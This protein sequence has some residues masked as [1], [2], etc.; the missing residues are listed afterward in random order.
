ML[1]YINSH[2]SG[3]WIALGFAMLAA[4]VLLFGFTT[5]IFLFAGV[6]ALATGLLMMS[7][8]LPESWTAGIACFGIATGLSSTLLWKPLKAMQDHAEPDK[9]PQ[10]DLVGL[11]F[12]LMT[13][14]DVTNPAKHRYSGIDW[15]VEID[16]SSDAD[17]IA[18]GQRVR[19]V[20]VEVGLLRVDKVV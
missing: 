1:E 15:K 3:F 14:I 2:L 10:S 5:I 7:G 4:E 17:Q 18:K 19:V 8:L 20:S 9:K 16:S 13:D 12:V 11:E 6:G